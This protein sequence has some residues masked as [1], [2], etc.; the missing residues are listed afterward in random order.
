MTS[1]VDYVLPHYKTMSKC[2]H[3]LADIVS[4]F[5]KKNWPL[6]PPWL[7]PWLHY[8]A[9]TEDK[10]NDE[11]DEADVAEVADLLADDDDEEEEV[12][13]EEKKGENGTLDCQVWLQSAFSSWRR[14]ASDTLLAN[15]WSL[16]FVGAWWTARSLTRF[17]FA[18][19]RVWRSTG[20]GRLLFVRSDKFLFHYKVMFN[21]LIRITVYS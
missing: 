13:E 18:K 20:S 21:R 4:L 8:K 19:L 6:S 11:A 16:V 5:L 12:V 17:R 15:C 7:P 10:D 1:S 3:F 2:V 14:V 9:V